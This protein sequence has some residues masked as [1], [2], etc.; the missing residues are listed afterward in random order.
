MASNHEIGVFHLP[1]LDAIIPS[2]KPEE[3]SHYVD[4]QLKQG[5]PREA[6]TNNL[7]AGGW[8]K[9]QI[10]VAFKGHDERLHKQLT[11]PDRKAYIIRDIIFWILF[12]IAIFVAFLFFLGDPALV[13]PP[14]A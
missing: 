6:L 1:S 2:M 7:L 3:F 4:S 11:T 8:S 9:E 10:D 13:P 5:I 12:L 14:Q